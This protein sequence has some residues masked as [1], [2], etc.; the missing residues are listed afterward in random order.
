MPER[1]RRWGEATESW[2][3]GA[4]Y[5]ALYLLSV[6][7]GM[8]DIQERA[9]HPCPSKAR[10]AA[11]GAHRPGRGLLAGRIPG[12]PPKSRPQDWTPDL[13]LCQPAMLS[14]GPYPPVCRFATSHLELSR[15]SWRTGPSSRPPGWPCWLPPRP[16][17]VRPDGAVW[18]EDRP[19]RR[20]Y[21]PCAHRPTQ[22]RSSPQSA[23]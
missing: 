6:K 20:P 7:R 13:W 5:E 21:T 11:L 19:C 22:R 15:S 9:D 2:G 8:H 10:P 4:L 18:P 17:A 14:Q 23:F 1:S 3:W 16:R 12:H